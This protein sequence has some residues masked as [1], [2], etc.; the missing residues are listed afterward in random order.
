MLTGATPASRP[1]AI[2]GA[3]PRPPWVDACFPRARS[4]LCG[5]FSL[6]GTGSGPKS[7]VV[8]SG[9]VVVGATAGVTAPDGRAGAAVAR[10]LDVAFLGAG[11]GGA[12]LETGG[13]PRY[14][15]ELGSSISEDSSTASNAE[16]GTRLRSERKPS[17]QL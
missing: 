8:V 13:A 17:S 6:S 5:L 15:A 2:Q 14:W 16:A 1:S 10:G 9:T 3:Q 12:G 4:L 7:E 11:G